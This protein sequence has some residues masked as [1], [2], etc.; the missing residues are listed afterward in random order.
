M[1]FLVDDVSR[2][3]AS[4][5]SRRKMLGMVG[6]AIGGAMLASLGL[7]TAAFG[8]Q[9]PETTAKCPPDKTACGTK[10]CDPHQIC[11]HGICC[12]PG[13]INCNGTCCGGTCKNGVCCG[14]DLT[15]CGGACCAEGITC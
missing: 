11:V 5:F 7:R 12:P 2:I 8:S 10:C 1:S 4:S 13:N 9:T 14:K 15:H 6:S 3:V